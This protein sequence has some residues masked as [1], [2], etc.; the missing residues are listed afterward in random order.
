[1]VYALCEKHGMGGAELVTAG[2]KDMIKNPSSWR[3]YPK[4]IPITF[5]Y[6]EIEYAGYMIDS[7]ET[8]II[9]LGGQYESDEIYR[10]S[11]PEGMESAIGLFTAVCKKCLD[12]VLSLQKDK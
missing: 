2:A 9:S 8:Q 12:E 7:G 6:E 5:A 11:S 10:F 4:I 1:M 3:G